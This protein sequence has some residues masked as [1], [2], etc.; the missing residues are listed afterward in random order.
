MQ[1]QTRRHGFTP[2]RAANS[3]NSL[4]P[5]ASCARNGILVV[6]SLAAMLVATAAVTQAGERRDKPAVPAATAQAVPGSEAQA[7]V[8]FLARIINRDTNALRSPKID[9]HAPVQL[10]HQDITELEV[11]G[12]PERLADR[13]GAPVWHYQCPALAP[14]AGSMRPASSGSLSA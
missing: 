9:L 3:P 11:E 1:L 6:V 12:N 2:T 13:W 7:T 4:T 8:V 10:P 5:R 14:G